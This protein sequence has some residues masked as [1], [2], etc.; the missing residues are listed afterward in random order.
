MVDGDEF[1]IYVFFLVLGVAFLVFWAW[2][3]LAWSFV[4]LS[5]RGGKGGVL[6][7][8]F[9]VWGY[10]CIL[11]RSVLGILMLSVFVSCC[12]VRNIR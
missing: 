10:C 3:V 1:I 6:G 7:G 2:G 4:V 8:V 9:V 11:C 5:A 12:L